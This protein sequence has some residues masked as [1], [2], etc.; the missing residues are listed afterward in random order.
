[1]KFS[2]SLQLNSNPEW[3]EYYIA[4]S[5]LKK[6]I[7]TIENARAGT[8]VEEPSTSTDLETAP[9]IG[10]PSQVSTL[11]EVN[12]FFTKALNEERERINT[13]YIDMHRK[14]TKECLEI[15]E[16]VL[17]REAMEQLSLRNQSV[18]VSPVMLPG[19]MM[20][21]PARGEDRESM[22]A[23]SSPEPPPF[24][25]ILLWASNNMR[26]VRKE[27][28]QRIV[29]VFVSLSNLKEFVETNHTGFSKI[30]KKYEKVIGAKLKEQYMKQLELDF[31][32]LPTTRRSLEEHINVA[33]ESYARVATE[34]KRD[35]AEAELKQ[36]LRE[37][38][39]YKRNTIWRDMVDKE[40]RNQTIGFV[41][42]EPADVFQ[43]K[44]VL[45]RLCGCPVYVPRNSTHGLVILLALVLLIALPNANIFGTPAQNNCFAIL[46]FGSLLWAFE[47]LP[48]FITS[49]LVPFLVVIMRVMV[50][51]GERLNA[52]DTAKL[53]FSS[54]FGP[55]IMLLL[56]GFSLAGA[57]SKHNIAK[58]AASFIL[59]RAGTKPHFVLLANM[60][61]STFAS[62]WI[63]NVAAPVL[64]FS[65]ISPILR[66]LPS[67]SSYARCLVLG[68]AMAANVGGMASPIASPQN[69]IAVGTMSP[70]PSW[71]EWFAIALPV[72]LVLDLAIWALLLLI[73]RPHQ[74]IVPPELYG[75][76]TPKPWNGTQLFVIGVSVLTIVLWCLESTMEGIFG[77]MGVIAIIP[78]VFFYGFGILTK[79]DWNSMLWSGDPFHV[80]GD[81]CNGWYCSWKSS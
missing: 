24:F 8:Q 17:N 3:M 34:G 72:C 18:N 5:N 12:T 58:E 52:K 68:I 62:M 46:V 22:P 41:T 1:M 32:Y 35:L 53:I 36:N 74:E 44:Y 75:S 80:S 28:M 67:R 47:A 14:I 13:F 33:V 25:S 7:Y 9:L 20:Q 16:E 73:Y 51:N 55:V 69:I 66:N 59:G 81:A 61:V 10:V 4:Y 56:G 50:V 2:H 23:S 40:R 76:H 48:L 42:E 6:I 21:S 45:I 49:I 43:G 30:L 71:I 54:M 57:L 79:D 31:P 19:N 37:H 77:D 15:K 11:E 63:S 38:I 29:E 70:S 78:I 65:L 60:F 27:L 64:C 39:V 26:L